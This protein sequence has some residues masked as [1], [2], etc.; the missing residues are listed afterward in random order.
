MAAQKS[1]KVYDVAGSVTLLYDGLATKLLQQF[2]QQRLA[3]W[4]WTRVGESRVNMECKL[5]QIVHV[6]PKPLG[7]SIVLGE[8]LRFHVADD[9]RRR[10]ALADG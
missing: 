8:V 2:E 5:V 6:S 10:G 4:G 9:R 1:E 3:T 7:G